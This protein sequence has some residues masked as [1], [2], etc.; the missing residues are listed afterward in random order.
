MGEAMSKLLHYSKFE[1]GEDLSVVDIHQG[2][3]RTI[4][5]RAS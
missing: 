5:T 3:R 1:G 2:S 4:A